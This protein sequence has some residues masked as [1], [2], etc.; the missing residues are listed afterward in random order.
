MPK[1]D[2]A[3]MIEL[4][5]CGGQFMD[6]MQDYQECQRDNPNFDPRQALYDLYTDLDY[7]CNRTK[8]NLSEQ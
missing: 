4:A 5:A 3:T 6:I 7:L 2:T 8:L 1:S